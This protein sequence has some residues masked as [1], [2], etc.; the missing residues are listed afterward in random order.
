MSNLVIP[1][2]MRDL[3]ITIRFQQLI[4]DKFLA[5]AVGVDLWSPVVFI[6]NEKGD[7]KWLNY[8]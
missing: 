4:R 8:M 5:V 3:C 6:I 1:N 2:V 7:E